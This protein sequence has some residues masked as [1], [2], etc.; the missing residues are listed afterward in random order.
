MEIEASIMPVRL[1]MEKLCNSYA[2]RLLST[3]NQHPI[4]QATART[5]N[6]AIDSNIY[7]A[8]IPQ[9]IS[10]LEFLLARLQSF[11]YSKKIEEISN[12]WNKP[13]DQLISTTATIS[14]ARTSKEK[15]AEQHNALLETLKLKENSPLLLYT[16]GS[17][18]DNQTAAGYCLVRLLNQQ[19]YYTKAAAINL[20][21]HIEIMDAELFAVYKA[22]QAILEAIREQIYIFIDSQA[23]L[24][25][26]DKLSQTGGQ[27]YVYKITQI[28]QKLKQQQ[29]SIYF[30]WVPGHNKVAGNEHADRLAKAGLKGT[31]S[32][33]A[34]TSLSYLQKLAK[35]KT[36]ESWQTAWKASKI[37]TKGRLYRRHTGDN[38]RISLKPNIP[39]FPRRILS[40]YYQLKL[41][42]GFFKS[43][44]KTIGKDS[45]GRCFRNCNA[46]Q[47]P[48]HLVLYCK[49][50]TKQRKEMAKALGTT[51]S[52]NRLFNTIKGTKALLSFIQDTKIA[53]LEWLLQA[54]AIDLL[55]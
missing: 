15:A 27:Y 14:I 2:L 5:D 36:I 3:S 41:G 1:R 7:P 42:K 18:K 32:Q 46:T 17:K 50:Y 53:T 22:L 12:K 21:E 38:P 13:W 44:S 51:L 35:A 52:A 6:R 26:L 40:A 47:S 34:F 39:S 28:C 31:L 33:E 43:H 4:K 29:N 16:D 9:P 10:Q 23:A 54:G 24:K 8:F 37:Q 25:R 20:G 55:T 30:S 45:Y 49:H 19:A 11:K 48:T